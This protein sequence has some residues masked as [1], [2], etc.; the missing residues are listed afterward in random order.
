[1]KDPVSKEVDDDDAQGCTPHISMHVRPTEIHINKTSIPA[2]EERLR[3]TTG[4]HTLEHVCTHANTYRC[5]KKIKH[6]APAFVTAFDWRCSDTPATSHLW[7]GKDCAL[8][9][10]E[11]RPLLFSAPFVTTRKP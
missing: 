3:P 10:C 4:L 7:A 11:P 1:M 9:D 6:T 5:R 8:S 2:Y